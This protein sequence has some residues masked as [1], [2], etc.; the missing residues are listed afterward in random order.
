[1]TNT[2]APTTAATFEAG[3]AHACRSASNAGITY[4]FE[5]VKRTAKTVTVR[6]AY[7]K[8][9]RCGIKS[10]ARGEYAL[11]NGSHAW[12]PVIWAADAA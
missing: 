3:Q 11:P 8:E 10:D 6:D 1:M 2:E 9:R 7:G 12:A 4:T 5:I